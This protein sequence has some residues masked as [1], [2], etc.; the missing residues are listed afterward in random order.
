MTTFIRQSSQT[1][2][3]Y[4]KSKKKDIKKINT[5]MNEHSAPPVLVVDGEITLAMN[6]NRSRANQL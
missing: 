1:V 2:Y 6:K 3:N 4:V 5:D